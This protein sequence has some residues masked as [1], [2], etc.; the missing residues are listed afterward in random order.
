MTKQKK[1]K[2][3]K[4]EKFFEEDESEVKYLVYEKNF[5]KGNTK[6]FLKGKQS[7]FVDSIMLEGFLG[8]PTGFYLSKKGWGFGASTK[9]FFVL[10]IIR[11]IVPEGKQVDFIIT[12]EGNNYIREYANKVT[13][14]IKATELRRFIEELMLQ[15]RRNNEDI[16]ELIASYLSSKFPSKINIS[17][18]EYGVYQSGEIAEILNKKKVTSKLDEDDLQAIFDFF[19]KVFKSTIKGRKGIV[20]DLKIRLAKEGKKITDKIF[21]DEVI[22]EFKEKLSKKNPSEESW[23]TF[24]KEK[25]FPFL[26]NYTKIIDKE[27]ISVDINYP[28]FV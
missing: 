25:V 11:Q 26:T 7:L 3:D 23:Q 10:E 22:K 17:S 9:G 4:V 5:T 28:D 1:V 18:Q 19:P 27:N 12:K 20:K 21:L 24:L 8:I 2:K 13:I 14:K 16:R 6:Y 15:N